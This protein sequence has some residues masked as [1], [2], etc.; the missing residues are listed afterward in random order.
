MENRGGVYANTYGVH[1]LRRVHD[2][3]ERCDLTFD[4]LL[5]NEHSYCVLT[6]RV[7]A[8]KLNWRLK[9]ACS[10]LNDG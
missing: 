5:C 2:L 7:L 3:D 4:Y 6:R 10:L 1:N 8:S 9:D